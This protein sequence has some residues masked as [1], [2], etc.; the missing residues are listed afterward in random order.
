MCK[1]CV[2]EWVMRMLED[3]Y[4]KYREEMRERK[5]MGGY[6]VVLIIVC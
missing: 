4:V 6:V 3:S 1:L 2:G 5:C